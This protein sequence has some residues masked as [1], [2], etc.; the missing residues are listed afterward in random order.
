MQVVPH[1]GLN[2]VGR[3]GRDCCQR[4]RCGPKRPKKGSASALDIARRSPS[5]P[6]GAVHRHGDGRVERQQVRLLRH[7]LEIEAQLLVRQYEGF[8]RGGEGARRGPEDFEVACMVPMIV[9]DDVEA[10]VTEGAVGRL[11]P[12]VMTVVAIIAGLTPILWSTGAGADVMKRI[13]APMVGGMITSTILTL[14]VL[15]TLY[16]MVMP[17]KTTR[18]EASDEK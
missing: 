14:F 10:A 11:R 3:H 12:K 18:S 6:R 1:L 13:A 17:G 2:E 8:M 16:Q 7:I 15:P 5:D 9:A 4:Q